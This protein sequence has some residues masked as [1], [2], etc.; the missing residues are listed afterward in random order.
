MD[1]KK[2]RVVDF[3]GTITTQ[4]TYQAHKRTHVRQEPDLLQY[5]NG[6]NFIAYYQKTGVETII[7]HDPQNFLTIATHHNNPD[8]IAGCL[9]GLLKME[10]KH[11]E[12]RDCSTHP[13][14][15]L[16]V[17]ETEGLEQPILISFCNKLPAEH[18]SFIL[19]EPNKNEQ[20][21]DIRN[22]LQINDLIQ[23]DT[24]L[25]FYD[26]SSGNIAAA[27]SLDFVCVH[28]IAGA[29][30]EFR[31]VF[32]PISPAGDEQIIATIKLYPGT[33]FGNTKTDSP[34]G[35]AKRRVLAAVEQLNDE[36]E[37]IVVPR[38]DGTPSGF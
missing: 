27:R 15:A 17:W 35:S 11:N 2:C 10:L 5:L 33:F 31:E 25:D 26:D 13:A 19:S 9:A 22:F 3:D 34:S 16:D 32:E 8:F 24:V 4:N 20:I 1:S 37:S 7:K 18:T 21:D 14:F 30:P 36:E 6:K 28:P 12:T 29:D 23:Q 38:I